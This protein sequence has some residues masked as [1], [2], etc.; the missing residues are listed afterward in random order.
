MKHLF[1]VNPAAGKGMA[2]EFIP[3]I[4]SIFKDLEEHYIIEITK[5]P[6]HAQEIVK[7]YVQ[8]EDYRVYSI[9]GDGTLN[10]VLNGIVG[11]GSILGIIPAG[12]G[13]DFI[14]SITGFGNTENI[15]ERTIKSGD[16]YVD[17]A[18][19]NGRYYINV[20]SVGLDAEIAYNAKV[21]K[22][23]RFLSGSAAYI[24]SIFITLLKY[25]SKLMN[26]EID[27]KN[28]ELKTLLISVA[29]GKYYGGGMKV[30]PTALLDDGLLDICLIKHVNKLKIL[31]LFP[32]LIKGTHHTIKQVSFYKGRK[33]VIRSSEKLSLNIDGEIFRTKEAIFEVLSKAI[34]V[35]KV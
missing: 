20:A 4:H 23:S 17:L 35:I 30:A 6:G 28:T 29:N 5:R 18:S 13:N 21:F 33:V 27:G 32:K 11:S 24:F 15:L 2:M 3:K 7:Q 9:G 31:V 26:I 22:K 1:I 10:E 12:T 8:M 34:R 14:R 25:K 16:F 19:V